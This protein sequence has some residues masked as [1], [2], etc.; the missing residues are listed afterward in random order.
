MF[1]SRHLLAGV[2]GLLVACLPPADRPTPA[3]LV[4]MR[5]GAR[6]LVVVHS[7]SANTARFARGL[8]DQLEASFIRLE[9]PARAGDGF[10]RTPNRHRA[11]DFK[12]RQ[13]DLSGYDLVLL[14]CPIWYWRPTAFIYAFIKAHDLTGKRVV[15]FYTYETSVSDGAHAEWTQLVAD[16]G[17]KVVDIVPINRRQLERQPGTV[18]LEEAAARIVR[19]RAATRWAA[20]LVR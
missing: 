15:L 6:A 2:L 14:G 16:R 3:D 4:R 9:V 8:A 10:W 18:S 17:G 7:R 11:V 5:E 13:V 1:C 19:A 20:P 12:P